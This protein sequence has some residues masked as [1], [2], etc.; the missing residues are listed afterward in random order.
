MEPSNLSSPLLPAAQLPH[1]SISTHGQPTGTG[2]KSTGVSQPRS[3]V[4][5]SANQR[6][7]ECT[8]VAPCKST[9]SSRAGPAPNARPPPSIKARPPLASRAMPPPSEGD[10]PGAGASKYVS[11]AE[12]DRKASRAPVCASGQ[13]FTDDALDMSPSPLI[14]SKLGK[15]RC[16]VA[17]DP[18]YM[19]PSDNDFMSPDHIPLA[20]RRKGAGKKT[21]TNGGPRTA[22]TAA[23]KRRKSLHIESSSLATIHGTEPSELQLEMASCDSLPAVDTAMDTGDNDKDGEGQATATASGNE[24]QTKRKAKS[25]RSVVVA[26]E[27]ENDIESA[28]DM[29]SVTSVIGAGS[30]NIGEGLD[31]KTK[32]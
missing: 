4:S 2:G 32:P 17:F 18:T 10:V 21:S 25:R 11:H 8:Q 1:R 6:G 15:R 28:G 9:L 20:Q 30:E 31:G 22:I 24:K 27:W 14:V 3:Q 7:A 29:P 13:S 5:S 16:S 23:K 19:P 12:N 26:V